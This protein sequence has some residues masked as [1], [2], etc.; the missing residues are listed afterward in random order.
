LHALAGAQG[1]A[2]AQ[3]FAAA[4]VRRR[5]TAQTA[6]AA[7]AAAAQG[8]HG[9][10]GFTPAQG[11]HGLQGFTPAQGL[12]GLQAAQALAMT[13]GSVRTAP[14]A[15]TPARTTTGIIVVDSSSIRVDFIASSPRRLVSGH[16]PAAGFL[17]PQFSFTTA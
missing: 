3:G 10:Q 9:L 1:F 6:T 5:G 14:P 13:T 7:P 15:T 12:H 17:Q 8:L 11:L 4:A 2:T 16:R